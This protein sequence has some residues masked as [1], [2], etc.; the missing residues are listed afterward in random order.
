M[1]LNEAQTSPEKKQESAS[2]PEPQNTAHSAQ[3]ESIVSSSST[4]SLWQSRSV[5][6]ALVIFFSAQMWV[7]ASYYWGDYPWDER[8]SWRMFS[9]V[10][11]LSCQVQMWESAEHGQLC[12]D[13]QTANCVPVRLS[14][15]YHMVWVNLLKR[16]RLQVL[17]E[18][19]KQ[20]CS[21]DQSKSVFV[22]LSCPS[23]TPPHQQIIVQS[24]QLNLC[25]EYK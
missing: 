22:N 11:S 12:P 21:Q 23:P 10:R 24:P 5:R 19:S 18:L 8:F 17:K 25:E 14:S 9:T 16:G 2:P 1:T 7:A 15:R 3:S 20:E 4:L 6:L 13:G